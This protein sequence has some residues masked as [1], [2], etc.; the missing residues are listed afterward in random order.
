MLRENYNQIFLKNLE[1]NFS[2]K[3]E[4]QKTQMGFLDSLSLVLFSNI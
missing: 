1:S 2:F 3:T 4:C